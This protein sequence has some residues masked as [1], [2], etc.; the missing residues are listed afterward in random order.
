MWRSGGQVCCGLEAGRSPHAQHLV[1]LPEDKNPVYAIKQSGFDDRRIQ[2]KSVSFFSEFLFLEGGTTPKAVGLSCGWWL[3][4]G[5]LLG[6]W[7]SRNRLWQEKETTSQDEPPIRRNQDPFN[8]Q[9][10]QSKDSAKQEGAL[11]Y[12]HKRQIYQSHRKDVVNKLT[13]AFCCS[14]QLFQL[15]KTPDCTTCQAQ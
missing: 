6:L 15:G 1:R 3:L 14:I 2:N 12:S 8:T 13:K 9:W 5:V 4:D 7:T 10:Q 11:K